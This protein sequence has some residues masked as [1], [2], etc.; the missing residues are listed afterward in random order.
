MYNLKVH[1]PFSPD[2]FN[3]MV[4]HLTSSTTWELP[5]GNSLRLTLVGGYIWSNNHF[6][7]PGGKGP[8]SPDTPPFCNSSASPGYPEC[9]LAKIVA[10]GSPAPVVVRYS[11]GLAISPL[12]LLLIIF[13][14]LNIRDNRWKEESL[15]F[16][17]WSILYKYWQVYAYL[18]FP[19]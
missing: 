10:A 2:I 7:F 6:F 19:Y 16:Y 3:P 15:L 4:S 17:I 18:S 11:T 5:F 14:V 13:G 9:T 1:L 8:F 12:P